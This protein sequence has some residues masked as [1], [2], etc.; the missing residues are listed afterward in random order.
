MPCAHFA[1][2]G[3]LLVSNCDQQLL[4]ELGFTGAVRLQQLHLQ[5]PADGRAPAE[6]RLFVNKPNL[7]FTT[8]DL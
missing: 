4:F 2:P 8:A 6:V 5:A 7:D 3:A 1:P